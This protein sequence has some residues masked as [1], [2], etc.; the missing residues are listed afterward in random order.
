MTFPTSSTGTKNDMMI[1]A[2]RADFK[3]RTGSVLRGSFLRLVALAS[4][5]HPRDHGEAPIKA[6][7]LGLAA[8]T[9]QRMS[10]TPINLFP[11]RP[12][13]SLS[14]ILE[15]LESCEAGRPA[16]KLATREE[17]GRLSHRS[18]EKVEGAGAMLAIT[19]E[20]RL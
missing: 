3:H 17:R 4:I 9:P 8:L 1:P 19:V 2:G 6:T 20:D 12:D 13:P 5:L 7:G 16:A 18:R 15:S 14:V 10:R 11:G